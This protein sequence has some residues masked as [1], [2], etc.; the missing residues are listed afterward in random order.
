[1][2]KGELTDSNSSRFGYRVPTWTASYLRHY[3]E[4]LAG[5]RVTM[6]EKVKFESRLSMHEPLNKGCDI[7]YG[8]K[9]AEL[10]FVPCLKNSVSELIRPLR[11]APVRHSKYLSGEAVPGQALYL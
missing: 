2:I 8:S 3:Y 7:Y 9:I 4:N 11:P 1:M 5:L 10:K 6:D